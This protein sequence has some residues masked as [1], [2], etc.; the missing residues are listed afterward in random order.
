MRGGLRL[1]CAIAVAVVI[2][3]YSGDVAAAAATATGTDTGKPSESSA[4]TMMFLALGGMFLSMIGTAIALVTVLLK[5]SR[6]RQEFG[7]RMGTIEEKLRTAETRHTTH[8]GTATSVHR[9]E[10]TLAG[11]AQRLDHVDQ[12]LIQAIALE[13]VRM[14]AAAKD[15]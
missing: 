15:E 7:E 4:S 8:D 13:E 10:V 5:L 6:D 3:A 11:I 9:I 12:R 14:R 1:L 2:V